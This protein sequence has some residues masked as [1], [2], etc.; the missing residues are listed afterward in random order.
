MQGTHDL[1][2]HA[3]TSRCHAFGEPVGFP[4]LTGGPMIALGA[5]LLYLP[6][7]GSLGALIAAQLVF[8]GLGMAGA[9][10]VMRRLGAGPRGSRSA[11]PPAGGLSPTLVG[12]QG[13]GGTFVGF[14][15]LPAYL[16][17]D[18]VVL[19]A[20]VQRR[21]LPAVVLGY[22]LLRTGALFMDGYSFFAS[23]LVSVVLWVVWLARRRRARLLGAAVLVGAN[24]AAA[25]VYRVYVPIYYEVSSPGLFRAMSLDLYTLLVPGNDIWFASKLGIAA[26]HT[27]LWGDTTNAMFNY[28]GFAGL[29]LAGWYLVRHRRSPI[30]VALALAGVLALALALYP[31]VKVDLVRPA[32]ASLYDMPVGGAPALPWGNAL[33]HVPGLESIRATYLWFAVSRMALILLAGLAIAE[34]ARGPARRRRLLALGLAGVAL[35]EV[36]PTVPLLVRGYRANYD[37]RAQMRG[38]PPARPR[39]GHA[40][41]RARVL[42]QLRRIAQ[43]LPRELPRGGDRTPHLQRRRRQ[44]HGLRAGA[45][46][47]RGAC[48]HAR[49]AVRGG[50]RARA[51]VAHGRRRCLAVLPPSTQLGDMASLARAE[52]CRAPRVRAAAEGERVQG[53]A[54]SAV[55][56]GQVARLGD[57]VAMRAHRANLGS[58]ARGFGSVT[59]SGS[60]HTL[61]WRRGTCA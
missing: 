40:A 52:W 58:R 44:E 55:L 16:W 27:K 24:L 26:D 5:L 38:R 42:P 50:G 43:R 15:L 48:A 12:L 41:R 37:D 33:E 2:L 9:Y 3:L 13:F 10:G 49:P 25:V 35:V 7:V 23:G 57:R 46:A 19:D 22:T 30:A 59:R 18:L 51:E 45:L 56:D 39:A 20:I 6:G 53:R 8:V 36:L 32:N 29:A 11:R 31:V 54:L 61:K 1:G 34:L 21:R 47:A 60:T 4:L 28:A 17:V 14:A